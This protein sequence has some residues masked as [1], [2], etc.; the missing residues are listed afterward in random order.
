MCY[1]QKRKVILGIGLPTF[2]RIALKDIKVHKALHVEFY[3][4]A[5]PTYKTP[6]RGIKVMP[7]ELHVSK[8]D[9]TY[10]SRNICIERGL[11]SYSADDKKK[12]SGKKEIMRRGIFVECTIPKGSIYYT[13]GAEF[14]SNKL[15]Y[16]KEFVDVFP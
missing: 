5:E 14:V 8:I 4:R 9:I 6:Y 1:I 11:H 7:S 2:P 12:S 15:Q 10:M 16:P 3:T 13:N